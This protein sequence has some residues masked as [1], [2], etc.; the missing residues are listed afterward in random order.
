MILSW[1]HYY[2]IIMIVIVVVIVCNE[3]MYISSCLVLSCH[4]LTS[5]TI[6]IIGMKLYELLLH[7]I[8]ISYHIISSFL[9]CLLWISS[10]LYNIQLYFNWFYSI[11]FDLSYFQ[12]CI[13]CQWMICVYL[14]VC[15]S[16]SFLYLLLIFLF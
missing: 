1:C 8:T 6:V 13:S 5:I 4:E 2:W 3:S 16:F 14:S 11:D 15:L 7:Y 12:Y 10:P 9:L